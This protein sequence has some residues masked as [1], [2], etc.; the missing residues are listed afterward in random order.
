MY[1]GCEKELA[2]SKVIVLQTDIN[3]IPRRFAG[4]QQ[5]TSDVAR[6]G[7]SRFLFHIVDFYPSFST[8]RAF[9]YPLTYK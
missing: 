4:G 8:L 7:H 5:I 3:Y 1:R 9:H 2:M 6:M